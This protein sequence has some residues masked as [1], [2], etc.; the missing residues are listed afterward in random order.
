MPPFGPVQPGVLRTECRNYRLFARIRERSA[1]RCRAAAAAIFVA[2]GDR[3]SGLGNDASRSTG[4]E[5]LAQQPV[6]SDEDTDAREKGG[7]GGM[8]ILGGDHP[9]GVGWSLNDPNVVNRPSASDV[10]RLLD[11]PH[12]V[13]A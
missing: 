2:M 6:T 5:L 12:P 9:S 3:W 1:S 10:P 4:S 13:W 11:L 8:G 7:A